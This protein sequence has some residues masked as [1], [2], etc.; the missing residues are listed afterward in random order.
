MELS[1]KRLAVRVVG[2]VLVVLLAA[3]LATR[4]V[5]ASRLRAAQREFDAKLGDAGGYA[6]PAVP[7]NENAAIFLRA[8]AEAVYFPGNDRPRAEGLTTTVLDAWTEGDRAFLGDVLGR[9]APALELA[10]RASAFG[11][12][13][14]GLT[15]PTYMIEELSEKVPMLK[16]IRLQ[17]LLWLDAVMALRAG[18][19]E[20][21]RSDAAAMGTLATSLERESPVGALMV[22]VGAE[23][24]LE[25]AVSLWV[26]RGDGEAATG[27]A[28]QRALPQTDLRGAWRRCLAV[29]GRVGREAVVE[30][31]R[32]RPEEVQLTLRNDA[33][34][35]FVFGA[36]SDSRILADLASISDAVDTPYGSRSD[37]AG[38]MTSAV[39]SWQPLRAGA[40]R[41]QTAM[42]QRSLAHVALALRARGAETGA[43]PDSLAGIPD[44][45]APDPFAG[46]P[47]TYE[48]RPDGSAVLAIPD[49][50]ALWKKLS[51]GITASCPYTWVLPAPARP[52]PPRH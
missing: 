45:L 34:T 41:L 44:A 23:K 36:L 25:G 1:R 46:R 49:G 35:R 51:N 2:V 52:A 4:W 9:N 31:D 37:P 3:L 6:S 28:L 10:R 43:Y 11:R 29:A 21:L 16:L 32:V 14:Y 48:R 38:G 26:E 22:G 12:S 17:R 20:R 18:E 24:I 8:A 13:S 15:Y 39:A 47:L 40:A 30:P 19:R 7:E 27:S 33:L 42:A 50:D 5:G